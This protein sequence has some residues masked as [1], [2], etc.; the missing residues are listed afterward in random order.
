MT[1]QPRLRTSPIV[2]LA[3]LTGRV[4]PLPDVPDPVFSGGM[5]GDGIGIDPAEGR[6]LA[7]CDGVVSQLAGTGH[8]LTITSEEGA[9]V[10]LHIGI[11]TVELGGEGFHALVAEGARVHAGDLLVEF[12]LATVRRKARS[13]VSVVAIANGDAYHIDQRADGDVTAGQAPLLTVRWA[14]GTEQSAAAPPLPGEGP[15]LRRSVR[16]TAPGGL[17]ARPAARARHAARGLDARVEVLF[18]DRRAPVDSVVALL[19]L[20]AGEGTIVELLATG[21]QAAL[22]VDAVAREL[23]RAIDA[24]TADAPPAALPRSGDAAALPPHVLAGVCAAPGIAIGPLVHAGVGVI[25]VPEFATGTA[26]DEDHRLDLALAAADA[27][28]TALVRNAP[29]AAD[30]FA[31][32][33]VL[34]EDPVLLDAAREH[35]SFGKSAGYAWRSAIRAQAGVLARLD[36]PL[37]AG[38]AADLRDVEQRVLHALGH[39]PSPRG[40]LPDGAVLAADDFTPSDLAALDR[41]R[42]AALVMARGGATS[43][44]AIIARHLGIPA[45]VAVGDALHAIRNETQ[46]VVDATAGRID[47]APAALE[48]ERARTERQRLANVRSTNRQAAGEATATRDGRHIEVAANIA[49][50]GDAR[51]AVDHGADAV[52]LLRTELLFM[53]RQAAPGIAEHR[54]AYQEIVD[55]LQGR[56]AII[57]T[58]DVGADKSVG[59]LAL[60]PEQNPALGLRG[61]RLA[62]VR[63]DL[64][65][66]QLRGLLAVQPFGR[67]RIMLPMVTDVPELLRIRARIDELAEAIGRTARIEVGVMIEVPAAALLAD[68]LA[69][70]ADFLSIGT[71][72]LTQ[73][74]LAM[75]R[76]HPALAAQADSL[77]P[78]VLRLVDATVRGAAQ[79]GKWVGVCGAMAAD[80]DA[81]PV[82]VGLGVSELSVAP[83]AVPDVKARVRGLDYTQCRR[84]AAELLS[85]ASATEVRAASRVAWPHRG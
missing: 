68:Q 62:Q 42:V 46:V 29:A 64:L 82:L 70:H 40:T 66:D 45:L 21:S 9:E 57:R 28:L 30:I 76:G 26:A 20:G 48:I 56:S 32:H 53:H 34:L 72:D 1:T 50:N 43:H 65:D 69:R 16:L 85:L 58:L 25:D 22:A 71:N 14:S 24:E 51:D 63:P 78:A 36:D 7:P 33:R 59:Y 18:G 54:A 80:P 44:A 6:L 84:V 2:L 27:G 41:E 8:A 35:V 15:A 61:I 77:H 37:L 81:V 11:D 83:L 79:H 60:P 4:V 38:R 5:L 12:D 19:G 52:G 10:L 17:H 39:A 49:T 3:P 74:T 47:F 23:V 73:Y 75:D 67:V 31:V 13:A 55:T